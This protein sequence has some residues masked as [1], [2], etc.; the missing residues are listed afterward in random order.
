MAFNPVLQSGIQPVQTAVQPDSTGLVAGALGTALDFG[1]A[2]LGQ[3]AKQ[4]IVMAKQQEAEQKALIDERVSGAALEL[5]GIFSN[6]SG[7]NEVSVQQR[8][9]ETI[10]RLRN[11]GFS[12]SEIA[13]SVERANK[14]SGT[15]ISATVKLERSEVEE[16][17]KQEQQFREDLMA[18]AAYVPREFLNDDGTLPTEG[19][20]MQAAYFAA[21]SRKGEMEARL[22]R[23]NM[24]SAEANAQQNSMQLRSRVI[25]EVLSA[26]FTSAMTQQ[27]N[28]YDLNTPEGKQTAIQA[29][30]NLKTSIPAIINSNQELTRSDKDALISG[31]D[32][33]LTALSDNV[34]GETMRGLSAKQ[35]GAYLEKALNFALDTDDNL[36]QM[37]I[38]SAAGVNVQETSAIN[39]DVN[40][41]KTLYGGNPNS[42]TLAVPLKKQGSNVPPEQAL[43]AA[44]DAW[45]QLHTPTRPVENEGLAQQYVQKWSTVFAAPTRMDKENLFAPD[46]MYLKSLRQFRDKKTVD[47][48]GAM[49]VGDQE[50]QDSFAQA[51][52]NAIGTYVPL[53]MNME[54]NGTAIKDVVKVSL[55]GG[56]AQIQIVSPAEFLGSLPVHMRA[57]KDSQRAYYDR[58]ASATQKLNSILKQ[59]YEAAVQI[60]RVAGSNLAEQIRNTQ[61][62]TVQQFMQVPAQ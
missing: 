61:L 58:A 59:Q 39:L 28:Q 37:Y 40:G 3:Q 34:T 49:V 10:S 33:T 7:R 5:S 13:A 44:R 42:P 27:F 23:A 41:F 25:S 12:E 32:V 55:A 53:A 38:M 20:A 45:V 47:N 57:S 35:R 15:S 4:D 8:V 50:F 21:L 17:R 36:F 26:N 31:L 30:A 52:S 18:V 43:S 24:T 46:G 56:P 9:S 2:V 48:L 29:I 6:A 62:A 11:D 51:T 19:E 1:S 54:F 14:I 60:D 16:R 22:S